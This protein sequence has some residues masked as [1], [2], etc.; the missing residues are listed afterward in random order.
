MGAAMKTTAAAAARAM[1]GELSGPPHAGERDLTG[2]TLDSRSV[3][4]GELFFAIRGERH[5][6]HGFVTDA[7]AAGAAGAVVARGFDGP[8]PPAPAFLIRVGDTT[9]AL[10]E[11]ARWDRRA[12]RVRIVA[13]TGS[14][15]KTT[16]REAAAAA[17]GSTWSV[18]QSRGN[19]NNHWGVPL[20]LLSRADEDVGVV[21]LGMSAPGEIATLTRIA[22]PDCGLI[23]RVAEAHLESFDS[24]DAIAAAKG[25]LFDGLRPDAASVVNRDDEQVRALGRRRRE[26]APRAQQISYGFGDGADVE[27]RRYR[28]LDEGLA[29]EARAFSGAWTG[30][31]CRLTGRHNASN[32]L[33]GLAAA[34][35]MGVPFEAAA[36]AVEELGPLPGRG[37]RL[38]HPSGAVLWDD[39]YNASPAAVRALIAELAAT[40]ARRRVLVAGDMRELGDRAA[41]FHAACGAAARAAGFDLVVGVGPLGRMLAEAAGGRGGEQ[42]P[43]I[44][45]C[46]SVEGV[47]LLLEAELRRGDVALFKASRAVGL[48]AAVRQLAG[49]ETDGN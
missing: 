2:V 10:G 41:E 5:D 45:T 27:G 33:G 29:F 32:V 12:S 6:G 35:A 40:P 11:L 22:A 7:V 13:I 3:Q 19:W 48:D 25:E 23:T 28:S 21:E 39:T 47:P 49:A 46:D 31:S 30:V 17:I 36:A 43:R 18:F 20:S 38:R 44:L 8:A 14:V 16:T 15:G 9:E 4:P 37:R 34:A 26:R 1:A 42:R 24:V